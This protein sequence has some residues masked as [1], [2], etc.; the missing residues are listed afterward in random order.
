M[1]AT[2]AL[3][4]QVRRLCEARQRWRQRVAAKQKE[5]RKLRVAVRDL[6]ASRELWK[7]RCRPQPRPTEP[8]APVLL[9]LPAPPAG[10]PRGG[11]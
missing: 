8:P 11:P 5:I 1:T 10:A 3:K 4:R 2:A 9:P 7:G 6:T